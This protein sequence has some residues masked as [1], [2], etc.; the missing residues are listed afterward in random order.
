[1]PPFINHRNNQVY[2]DLAPLVE[3]GLEQTVLT[4]DVSASSGTITVKNID[5]ITTSDFLLL[6]ELGEEGSEIVTT[7]AST[8]PSG[9]TVTLAA[10]TTFA[11]SSGKKVYL[12]QFNQ[13]EISHA[14]TLTGSKSVKTTAALQADQK[15]QAYT[16]TT[17]S[18]G[19]Y[20][21]RFK[22]SV[23]SSFGSYSGGVPYG[24]WASS[25]VGYLIE[26]ALRENQTTLSD[27][28]SR[29][30]C[31]RWLNE[32]MRFFQGKQLRFPQ[33]QSINSI[34]GQTTRGTFVY[35]LPSDIYDNDTNKSI[36]GVRVGSKETS[37]LWQDPKEFEEQMGDVK[38]T[39]VR[40]QASS[41]ATSLAVDN[42]YDFADGSSASPATLTAY[43]SGSKD[44]FTY[45]GV[46][47]DDA[48][49]GTAAFTGV[50]ASGTNSIENTLAVDTYIYQDEDEG[51]PKY[52]TV[53]NGNLEIWPLPDGTRDNKNIYIDYFT[54]ATEV[55]SDDDTL[56]AQRF[57]ILLDYLTWRIRMKD[58]NYGTLDLNDGYYLMFKEKLNDAIRTNR[59]LFTHKMAPNVNRISY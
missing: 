17:E 39:Q 29:H 14:D 24:G 34:L 30:D 37:L 42:S 50:P 21:A 23:A 49:G 46:T 36:V 2:V 4:A 11:H 40:T 53:R 1:M 7:H 35:S 52:Y 16:D 6:G 15:V 38:F 54:E 9:T 51:E 25:Q 13:V 55:D 44:S 27:K 56:D 5:N 12:I 33:H 47:R 58:K 32:G 41:G 3:A 10:N 28:I 8:S 18:A 59:S 22:D 43:V 31:Y 26:Q 19:F 57:E 48:D 45:T 20:F